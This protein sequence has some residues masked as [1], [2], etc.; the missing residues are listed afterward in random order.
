VYISNKLVSVASIYIEN[1]NARL[2]KFATLNSY[3]KIGI[4]SKMLYFI[5]DILKNNEINYF[6][7]DA[8]KSAIG[9]Y[10][11]FGFELEG[12]EFYKSGILYYKMS[13]YL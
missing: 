1:K 12:K 13:K 6:W 2:R 7:F 8:R 5:L 9:F 4:G 3:Q 11:K 10:E